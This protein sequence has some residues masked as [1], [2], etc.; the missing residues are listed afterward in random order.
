MKFLLY[1]PKGYEE[2]EHWPLL[3]FMHGSGERG[4]DLNLVKKH[5][6]PKLIE[7][8][9]DFPFIIISPQC[10]KDSRWKSEDV[11]ALLDHIMQIHNVDDNRVYV[12]GLSMGGAGTWE[13]AGAVPDKL[14]AIAP[15]CGRSNETVV[16]KIVT[17]PTWIFHGAK[18]PTVKV[19]HSETMVRLLKEKGGDPKLTIYPEAK[20]DSWTETYDNEEFYTWLLSHELKMRKKMEA[21]KP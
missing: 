13:V 5:G 15:I 12:T 20:H 18:D 14:A 11:V 1:L 21:D 6:P 10:P 3:L 16:E 8:G 4:D 9:K 2:Q 17:I 7:N 19:E